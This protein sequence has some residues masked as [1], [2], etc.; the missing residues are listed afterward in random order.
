MFII[1]ISN[2]LIGNFALSYL[3]SLIKLNLFFCSSVCVDGEIPVICIEYYSQS[4]QGGKIYTGYSIVAAK[5][6]CY[7]PASQTTKQ[8][9]IMAM[10][11]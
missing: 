10:V 7:L 8:T 3:A 4:S 9:D 2:I 5:L 6:S 11:L 1:D